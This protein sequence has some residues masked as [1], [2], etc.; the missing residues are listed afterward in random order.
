MIRSLGS[1][2]SWI[3]CRVIEKAPVMIDW[4]AMMVA[5]VA[6]TMS[7]ISK[8]PGQSRKKMLPAVGAPSSTSRRLPR[9]IQD[10]A[11]KHDRKPG[12]PD[13][14]PAEMPHIGIERLGAGDAQKH[15]AQH[16]KAVAPLENR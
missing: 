10:Q 11:W 6:S 9:V 1:Q 8:V 14:P 12:K 7:G 16:P 2:P 4:L 15:R 13:R 5:T 3:A